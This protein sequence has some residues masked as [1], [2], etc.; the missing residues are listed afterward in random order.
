MPC[1]SLKSR[2]IL[3]SF[4]AIHRFICQLSDDAHQRE[5]SGHDASFRR[6]LGCGRYGTRAEDEGR[7]SEDQIGG[8]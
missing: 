5:E 7:D 3:L 2:Q 6:G 8:H 4:S 1:N